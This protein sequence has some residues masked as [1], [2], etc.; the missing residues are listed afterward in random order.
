MML[1]SS[2]SGSSR[3]FNIVK[4]NLVSIRPTAHKQARERQETLLSKQYK[5]SNNAAAEKE[6]FKSHPK[7]IHA[8]FQQGKATVKRACTKEKMMLLLNLICNKDGF[9]TLHLNNLELLWFQKSNPPFGILPDQIINV[10]S[11]ISLY[12]SRVGM[13]PQGRK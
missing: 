2:C 10:D 5:C 4:L 11:Y 3:M 7:P 1:R 13:K 9:K 6:G 8:M 12:F